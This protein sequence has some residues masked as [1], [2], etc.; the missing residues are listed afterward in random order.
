MT[1][2]IYVSTNVR[3]QRHCSIHNIHKMVLLSSAICLL[4]LNLNFVAF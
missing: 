4:H 2:C 3:V 1:D